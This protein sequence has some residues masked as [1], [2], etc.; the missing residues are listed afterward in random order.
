VLRFISVNHRK[1]AGAYSAG[2]RRAAGA[3]EQSDKRVSRAEVRACRYVYVS[4]SNKRARDEMRP[5][6]TP[7]IELEKHEYPQ[8]FQHNMPPSGK[9]E[10]VNY[11]Y[12]VDIGQLIVGN[13]D[14]VCQLIKDFYDESGGF[15]TLL[16][17][18]GKDRGTREQK[19]R[20]MKLFMQAVAPQ[21]RE[22]E[23]RL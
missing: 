13:P 15:G 2:R 18:Y 11:D 22:L 19:A 3:S 5:F 10:A 20:S 9:V 21:L 8:H 12:L 23:P 16:L 17:I 14:H 6:I 7:N 1:S 4:N